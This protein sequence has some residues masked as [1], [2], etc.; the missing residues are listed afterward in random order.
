[1]EE[2]TVSV[3]EEELSLMHKDY[4]QDQNNYENNIVTDD[5]A[6]TPDAN[7]DDLMD[8]QSG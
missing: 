5:M 6:S 7:D 3:N 4:S 1:M 2:I 8:Y